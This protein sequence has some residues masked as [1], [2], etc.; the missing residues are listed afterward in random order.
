MRYRRDVGRNGSIRVL[1]YYEYY[2][3]KKKEFKF[4]APGRLNSI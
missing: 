4:E 2:P 1:S 3:L